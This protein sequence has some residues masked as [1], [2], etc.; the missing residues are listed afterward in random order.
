MLRKNSCKVTHLPT[1]SKR[2]G[3]ASKAIEK[4]TESKVCNL[5]TSKLKKYIY[6]S[7]LLSH[8]TTSPTEVCVCVCLR[9]NYDL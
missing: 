4:N 3:L 6:M 1:E 9:D 7:T 8:N 2:R 5:Q